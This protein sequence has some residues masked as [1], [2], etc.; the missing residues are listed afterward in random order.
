ML[1]FLGGDVHVIAVCQPSVPVLAAVARMEAD[2]DPHVPHS[3]VLMGGPIDTRIN[4]TEVN[5]LAERRGIDWFRRNV[6]TKVPFPNPGFMRDVYPGFLQLYG[7]MSMNLDRHMEAHRNLYLNLVKGDGD[8]AQKHREFYDEYL[9]VMDLCA[10]F[11]LQTCDTVFIRHALP[12]GEMTHRGIPIDPSKIR[13]VALMTVEGEND[14]ISGVGQTE[15]A[16]ALCSNIPRI[17]ST[18]GCSPT[19]ATTAC[20]TARA[21]APRSR[22]AS[23]I[24]CSRTTPTARA[25]RASP[26]A[27]SANGASHGANGVAPNGAAKP[28]PPSAARTAAPG[29]GKPV[30]SGFLRRRRPQIGR[31][32]SLSLVSA[33]VIPS[34]PARNTGLGGPVKATAAVPIHRRPD[35]SYCSESQRTGPAPWGR[36]FISCRA[37]C[38][39]LPRMPVFRLGRFLGGSSAMS[40]RALLYRRPTE[41]PAIDVVFDKSIYLVRVRRHRQARRYTLRIDAASREVVLTIPPRGSLQ[42]SA[43]VRAEAR[44]VDRGATAAPAAGDAVRARRGR[45]AP[46]RAA[47]HRASAGCPRHGLDR[48]GRRRRAPALRRR[49]AAA[50]QPAGRR[51]PQAR[52]EARSRRR[53]PALCQG[54][55]R[56]RQAHLGARPVEPLGLVLE[57]GRAVVLLAAHPRAALRARLSRRA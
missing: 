3:M 31:E 7:F 30:A 52:S 13:R 11:Y 51:F 9:A 56:H 1:H 26:S 36:A 2:G 10:E 45:A 12:K 32:A 54:A 47:S 27:R 18:T 40:L 19:S 44:R 48:T 42:G 28:S 6:I 16:H 39:H 5:L 55:R 50:S 57:H 53:E 33:G 43:G 17:A 46:R 22:R 49:R 34:R 41:P 20:S 15:A 29:P 21:S 4:P 23:P 8:S 24:S 38:A 35:T 25:R 14:D 37:C